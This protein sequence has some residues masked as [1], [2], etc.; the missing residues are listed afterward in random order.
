MKK[1]TYY[2]FSCIFFPVSLFS[3]DIVVSSGLSQASMKDLKNLQQ[4]LIA[5]F[6][7]EFKNTQSFPVYFQY[8]LTV[9]FKET[10]KFRWGLR[11]YTTSTGARSVYSDYSGEVR[12]DQTVSCIGVVLHSELILKKF[13]RSELAMVL[14]VGHILSHLSVEGYFKLGNTPAETYTEKFKSGNRMFETGLCYRYLLND[15]LFL[16][17]QAGVQGNVTRELQSTV[18][19]STLDGFSADWSGFKAFVGLGLR[20]TKTTGK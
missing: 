6:P 10:E 4:Y 12:V 14:E 9:T 3:Q 15:R 11:T 5:E 20:F 1:F 13:A 18:D 16:F 8:N 2:L 19:G 17:T 7:V